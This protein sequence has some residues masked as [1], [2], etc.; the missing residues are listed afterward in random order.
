MNEHVDRCGFELST[1]L[2]HVSIGGRVAFVT[3]DFGFVVV[4]G[5]LF[6]V[7][8]VYCVNGCGGISCDKFEECAAYTAS[9]SRNSY[10]RHF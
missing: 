5:D 1:E 9:C 10:C 4:V 2:F 3:D 7:G 8:C 6:A